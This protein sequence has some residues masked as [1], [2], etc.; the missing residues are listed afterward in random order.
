MQARFFLSIQGLPSVNN[1]RSSY[2]LKQFVTQK[3]LPC[4]NLAKSI[5]FRKNYM[6]EK[7][8]VQSYPENAARRMLNN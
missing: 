1:K 7:L 4:Y 8:I 5:M 3:E 2:Y 6:K